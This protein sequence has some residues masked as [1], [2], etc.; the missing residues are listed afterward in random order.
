M[1]NSGKT[2]E[3]SQAQRDKMSKTQ[4]SQLHELDGGFEARDNIFGIYCEENK[5]SMRSE[6]RSIPRKNV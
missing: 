1:E 2:A 6:M 5:S 3:A 4:F